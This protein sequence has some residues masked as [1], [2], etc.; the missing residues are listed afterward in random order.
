MMMGVGRAA[1]CNCLVF[2]AIL[3]VPK[4]DA[5]DVGKMVVGIALCRDVDS[6][7]EESNIL[8]PKKFGATLSSDGKVL[9][10][11]HREEKREDD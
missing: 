8:H 2:F 7:L 4:R 3:L 5:N 1:Q 9:T 10:T 11:V 6:V